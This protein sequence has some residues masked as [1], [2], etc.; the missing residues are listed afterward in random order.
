MHAGKQR[1]V[2]HTSAAATSEDVAVL[3]LLPLCHG[4]YFRE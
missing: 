2:S 4:A 3:I 1:T